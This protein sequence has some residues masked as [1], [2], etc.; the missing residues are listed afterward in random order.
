VGWPRE[1]RGG[2]VWRRATDMQSGSDGAV[3]VEE[4][5]P[6]I[7]IR[8]LSKVYSKGARAIRALDGIDLEIGAGMFGLLGPNGA[9]KTTLMRILAGIG[10]RCRPR[11]AGSR[12][13]PCWA[14]CH[15]SWASTPT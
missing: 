9:G 4:E 14:I 6:M 5:E 3:C 7:K 12:S 13:R 11:G 10:T 8:Q 2:D 15:R 1:A